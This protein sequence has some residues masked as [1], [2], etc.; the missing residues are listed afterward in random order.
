MKNL[1]TK[2]Y[3]TIKLLHWIFNCFLTNQSSVNFLQ[4][5]QIRPEAKIL[6]LEELSQE[7]VNTS[8][9]VL[10]VNLTSPERFYVTI[11]I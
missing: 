8:R 11:V 3:Y 2:L 5:F 6:T 1:E 4:C 10:Y 9:P 7:N